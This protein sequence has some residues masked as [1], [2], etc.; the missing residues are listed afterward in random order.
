[1]DLPDTFPDDI[2]YESYIERS[3]EML[4]DMGYITRNKQISFF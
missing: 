4:E 3:L 1:M 2:R